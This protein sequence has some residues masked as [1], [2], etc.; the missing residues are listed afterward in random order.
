MLAAF[1]LYAILV[2]WA[3]KDGDLYWKEIA[4]YAAIWLVLI[5]GYVLCIL[6]AP[7]SSIWFVVPICLMDVYL[8]LKFVG[9]PS[10][11]G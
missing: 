1:L 4:I 7:E 9:N 5:G 2:G 10:A 3:A 11:S 6:Y 8:L